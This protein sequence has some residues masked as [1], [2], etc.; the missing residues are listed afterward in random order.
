[1]F[2]TGLR[3]EDEYSIYGASV[4]LDVK[5]A[6]DTDDRVARITTLRR[7]PSE[8]GG[9]VMLLSRA[10]Y[11]VTAEGKKFYWPHFYESSRIMDKDLVAALAQVA[12]EFMEREGIEPI[13]SLPERI[14]EPAPLIEIQEFTQ[15][16]WVE[17]MLLLDM[18]ADLQYLGLQ[19]TED[20]NQA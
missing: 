10:T 4:W 18:V 11:E 6:L 15:V 7:K 1:M 9:V 12:A 20:L 19:T 8:L 5:E 3:A 13:A 17:A 14:E 16:R 2:L